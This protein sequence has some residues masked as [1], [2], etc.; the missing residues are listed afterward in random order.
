MRYRVNCACGATQPVSASQAGSTLRCECGR[1]LEVPLLS[2]LRRAAGEPPIPLSTIERIASMI[3]DGEAPGGDVC[4]YSGRPANDCVLVRVQCERSSV[5][6]GGGDGSGLTILAYGVL[7]G[8]IDLFIAAREEALPLEVLG[9]DTYLEIPLR[10]SSDVASQIA[11]IRRQR[12]LKRLLRQT[13][14]YAALLDEYPD[15]HVT[16]LATTW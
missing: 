10:V 7:F 13:P 11:R 3:R 15:A 4:P 12:T 14:I 2:I 8:W 9:R 6:G 16:P 5:R 1:P